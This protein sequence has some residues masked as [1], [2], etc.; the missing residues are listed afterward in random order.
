MTQPSPE[1][2]LAPLSL[3]VREL[4]LGRVEGLTAPQL[5]AFVLGWGSMLELLRRTDLTLPDAS[6]EVHD[7]IAEIVAEVERAQA[8]V[9]DD[10][11]D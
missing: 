7:A 5:A 4:L 2:N 3:L 6:Q 8:D 9:L 10:P 1:P 11:A